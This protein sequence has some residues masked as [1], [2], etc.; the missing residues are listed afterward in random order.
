MVRDSDFVSIDENLVTAPRQANANLPATEFLKL[1]SSSKLINSRT[2][3]GSP[4][5]EKA[6]TL[7]CFEFDAKNIE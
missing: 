3:I 6:P 7:G 2:A 4:F 1:V 5:N